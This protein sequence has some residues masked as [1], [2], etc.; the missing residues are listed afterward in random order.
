MNT[1]PHGLLRRIHGGFRALAEQAKESTYKM[2]KVKSDMKWLATANGYPMKKKRV[3]ISKDKYKEWEEPASL[4]DQ[5][6]EVGTILWMTLQ[7]VADFRG[8][9]LYE[10][11]AQEKPYRTISGRTEAE[12]VILIADMRR[13]GLNKEADALERPIRWKEEIY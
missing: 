9:Y 12:M 13:Q 2:E 11:N 1:L 3:R 8:L 6:T 5:P 4:K 10:Y 7:E